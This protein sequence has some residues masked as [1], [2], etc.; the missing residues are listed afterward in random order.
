MAELILEPVVLCGAPA[1]ELGKADVV[2]LGTGYPAATQPPAVA[3]ES[4]FSDLVSRKGFADPGR[5]PGHADNQRMGGAAPGAGRS[6]RPTGIHR[7]SAGAARRA[8]RAV[9]P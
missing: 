7:R 9:P 8:A 3:D 5:R 6:L 2:R 4:G 1:V